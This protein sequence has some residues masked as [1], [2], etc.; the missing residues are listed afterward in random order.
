VFVAEPGAEEVAGLWSAAEGV[1]CASI[2]YVEVCAALARRLSARRASSGKHRLD[3]Y[4]AAVQSVA[5]GDRLIVSAAELARR[6]RLRALDAVH[7]AAAL[8]TKLENLSLV[9][10]DRELRRAAQAEGLAISPAELQP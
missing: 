7:L 10:W 1:C 2:G 6:H 3:E 5:V 9:S 4:W 8:S